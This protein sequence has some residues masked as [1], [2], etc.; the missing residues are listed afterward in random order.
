MKYPN[1]GLENLPSALHC[2]CG[3]NLQTQQVELKRS[4]RD[5]WQGRCEEVT[6]CEKV[7][8]CEEVTKK[9]VGAL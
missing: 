8:R 3:C 4:V 2:D 1:C 5:Q 7:T 6:R 9:S